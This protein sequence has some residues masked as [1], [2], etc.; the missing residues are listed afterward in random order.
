MTRGRTSAEHARNWLGLTASVR[1]TVKRAD[2]EC[3]LD[4]AEPYPE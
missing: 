4:A 1:Q 3:K 2:H